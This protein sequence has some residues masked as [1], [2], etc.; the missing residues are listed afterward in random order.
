VLFLTPCPH[1]GRLKRVFPQVKLLGPVTVP[2]GPTSQRAYGL[3]LLS[4]KGVVSGA[5]PPLGRCE[6]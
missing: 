1:E 6:P 4:G 2:S 5:I 3:F